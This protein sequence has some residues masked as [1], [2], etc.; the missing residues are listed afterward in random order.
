MSASPGT[1]P[2]NLPELDVSTWIGT[3]SPLESLRGRVVLVEAFQMLCAGCVNYG[4]PQAQRVATMFPTVAV[5]GL[6][7]VFEHHEVTGPDALR[8]FLREFGVTFPVG[9]DRQEPGHDLPSTM[10][11]FGLEGTPSTL[12]FDQHGSLA[13]SH[14]GK[15]NDLALGAMIGQLMAA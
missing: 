13:F 6:N 1:A 12:L 8:V 15:V 7:T 2:T 4:I 9:I 11:Q 14:L 3:P 10:R 5:V